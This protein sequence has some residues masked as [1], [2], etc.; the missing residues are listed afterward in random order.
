MEITAAV[1]NEGPGKLVLETLRLDDPL[2]DE[3]L[4]DV[5]Y[6]GLCRS[7]LHEIE[8]IWPA[9]CPTVLGHEASGV[10]RAV[11]ERVTA[12]EPGDH[13][14]T[15][16]S[17]YCG[18]CRFCL[19][20]RLTLCTNRSRLRQRPR[21]VLRN[22]DGHSVHPT[23]GLGAFAESMVVHQHSVVRIP[24]SMSL[25]AASVLGC[26]V[27]T[28]L[29]AVFH[30]AAV[31]PGSSVAVVGCGGVGIAVIQGARIAGALRIIAIDRDPARLVDASRFGATDVVDSGQVDAVEA[32]RDLS[33]GGVDYSFEA[34][35]LAAT[36]EQAFAMLGPAGTAT[37][38]GLVPDDQPVSVKAS[39]LFV[40]EKRLQ[41]SLMGS[42][43]FP[44]DIPRYVQLHTQGRLQLDDMLSTQVDLAGVQQGFELMQAGGLTRIVA[45]IRGA[46]E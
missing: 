3:V 41:G 37:V 5:S 8:G 11:G 17:T 25:A 33:D 19:S 24:K 23:A 40:F 1:L 22:E 9:T 29:G 13:V 6:S 38:L 7:D 36:V 14:V 44:T 16:L 10:V 35:G 32:V 18:E 27:T 45:A 26:A 2:P 21:P 30:S 28:G 42:N 34:I 4:I 12:F 15:C 43:Q 20:G 46:G 39:D 31:R